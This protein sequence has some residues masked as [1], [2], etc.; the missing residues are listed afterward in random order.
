MSA[1][2]QSLQELEQMA[3]EAIVRAE[4]AQALTEVRAGF[5]GRKGSVSGL[6]RGL[7]D[8]D[9][10]DRAERGQQVNALKQRIED[11]VAAR[12]SD[13]ENARQA[14]ALSSRQLDVTLP[15]AAPPQGHLHP[16]SLVERDMREFF[17]GLGF[18]VEEGPDVETEYH[19][20]EALRIED[21]HP[22][23]DMQDSFFVEG[24]HVLRTHTSPVQIRAMTGRKPPFR[25]I[26]PGRTY[27]VDH[28]AT[29][30]PMFHQI[31]GFIVDDHTTFADLK[32]VLHA[33]ARHLVGDDVRLR[34]R[35]HFF[36]FTE[37]SA[38]MDF[39]WRDGWLEW[40]GCGMIHPGVL[41]NCGIDSRK[42]QG[43][44]FGMGVDRTA[45]LRFGLPNI[46]MLF[47]G[48]L[49]RLEQV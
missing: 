41:E 8:L 9:P 43:F 4:S 32:G 35:A 36:P 25:F 3:H 23:R 7:G 18:S 39:S 11:R 10:A 34:F 37:P 1:E 40:G 28:G 5:L 14:S 29:K 45:M 31:E 24:G 20:F 30:S 22:A 13:L 19:N 48:D 21:D 6:L 46:H 15:G 49:R 42:Y 44:A 16:L 12:R 33:F 38:E 27:R 17:A 26:A 2:P 47:D